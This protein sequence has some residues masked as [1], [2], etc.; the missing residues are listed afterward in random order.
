MKTA[1]KKTQQRNRRR[2]RI[3]AKLFGTSKKPRISVFRSNRYVFSQLIDDEKRVTVASSW[4]KSLKGSS[5]KEKSQEAGKALAKAASI[6][7]IKEAVFDRGGYIYTGVV[8]SFAEGAR[9]G[10]LKF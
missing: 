2:G 4:S 9:E 7:G 6:K 8:K 1:N 5:F 10:G 3:R